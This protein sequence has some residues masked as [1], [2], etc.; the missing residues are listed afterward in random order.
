MESSQAKKKTRKRPG[1]H[2]KQNRRVEQRERMMAAR[3]QELG[4][5]EGEEGASKVEKVYDENNP[6][7]GAFSSLLRNFPC[8]MVMPDV[9]VPMHVKEQE[10]QGLSRD[11]VRLLRWDL[12]RS[13]ISFSRHDGSA[14][15]GDV[16]DFFRVS[17]D[18]VKYSSSAAVGGK[19]RI[20]IYERI[21]SG[22]K[23]VRIAALGGHGFPVFAPPGHYMIP[24]E[25]DRGIEK[26]EKIMP[27]VHETAKIGPIQ[28]ANFLSAMER[29]GG[30]NFN[31]QISGGYRPNANFEVTINE[32]QLSNAIKDGLE[33]FQ[34]RF[35]CLVYGVGRWDQQK[36]WWDGKI[37]LCYTDISTCK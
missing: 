30:V 33:F 23:E 18:A 5:Q 6:F 25:I 22:M 13:Q 16:S 8:K 26:G 15:I 2:L 29:K 12:P 9:R 4:E 14:L 7:F 27:L 31:P 34:N 24:T 32:T 11:L 19:K 36:V 1:R 21:S 37:P 17:I 3:E 35:S 28:R 20:I 10:V